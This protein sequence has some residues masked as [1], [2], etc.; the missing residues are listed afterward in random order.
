MMNKVFRTGHGK[1]SE[2]FIKR[3]KEYEAENKR[4]TAENSKLKHDIEHYLLML[5]ESGVDSHA[6]RLSE[7]TWGDDC[8]FLVDQTAE[9]RQ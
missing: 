1:A 3:L 6:A 5:E 7:C 4:L 2:R 9:D 8:P